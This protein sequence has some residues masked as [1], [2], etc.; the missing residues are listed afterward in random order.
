[1]FSNHKLS[2]IVNK[3]APNSF[4]IPINLLFWHCA[5]KSIILKKLILILFYIILSYKSSGQINTVESETTL[6]KDTHTQQKPT[7]ELN[8]GPDIEVADVVLN[9]F[10]KFEVWVTT[11]TMDT[12]GDCKLE[13]VYKIKGLDTLPHFFIKFKTIP[14]VYKMK[15]KNDDLI[16]AGVDR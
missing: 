1:M 10:K 2:S 4:K 13:K 12:I 5:I 3:F 9:D 7:I 8:V 11:R 14:V 16:F 15:M 6:E